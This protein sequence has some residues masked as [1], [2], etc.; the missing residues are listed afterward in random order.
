LDGA[1]GH[2]GACGA[3]G[4]AQPAST[5]IAVNENQ[6]FGAGRMWVVYLEVAFAF[7]LA[8]LIVWWTWPKKRSSGNSGE[9]QTPDDQG[10][11]AGPKEG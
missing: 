11:G 5:T 10:G 7:L 4:E 6:S 1:Q 8:V 2:S 3:G 9:K